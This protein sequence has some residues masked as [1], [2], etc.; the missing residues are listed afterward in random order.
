MSNRA[1]AGRSARQSSDIAS[2]D[3][4]SAPPTPATGTL[5]RS[6]FTSVW[7]SS[8]GNSTK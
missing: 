8:I 5:E 7:I 2:T 4:S 3:S 6:A 1:S